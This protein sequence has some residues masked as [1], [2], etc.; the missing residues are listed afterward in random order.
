M[1]S[2]SSSA[3]SSEDISPLYPYPLITPKGAKEDK[4]KDW[5]KIG[6][7]VAAVVGG[8]IAALAVL[9]IMGIL[10]HDLLG[11]TLGTGITLIVGGTILAPA[12][13]ILFDKWQN[14]KKES[15]Q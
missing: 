1:S 9:C 14:P 15:T 5:L 12:A 7:I 2:S 3:S 4:E 11:G 13:Y 6:A 8:L 10:P